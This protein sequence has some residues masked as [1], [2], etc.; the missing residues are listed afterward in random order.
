MPARHHHQHNLVGRLEQADA[1]D[2]QCID[3]IPASPGLT[4]DFLDR[5]FG[6]AGIVLQH[7]LRD[8]LALVHVAH[9]AHKTRDRPDL[10]VAATQ[11]RNFRAD[12]EILDLYSDCHFQ[13]RDK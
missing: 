13:L 1:V 6:H 2:H 11:R 3:N 9:H 4:D 10:G 8:G 12:I 5:L 7:H